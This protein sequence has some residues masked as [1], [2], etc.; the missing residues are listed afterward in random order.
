[1][2][3]PLRR[4][5]EQALHV[6]TVDGM[7]FRGGRAWLFIMDLLGWGRFARFLSVPPFIWFVELSYRFVAGNRKL[8][9]RILFK[10]QK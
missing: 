2:T 10:H 9:S 7:A 3:E 5:C 8:F 1:M 4:M 6:I